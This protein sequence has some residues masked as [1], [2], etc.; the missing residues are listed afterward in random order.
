MRLRILSGNGVN[1]DFSPLERL[2]RRYLPDHFGIKFEDDAARLTEISE[3]LSSI[4][5][6][7]VAGK[8]GFWHSLWGHLGDGNW[9]LDGWIA[10][11]PND[12]GLAVVKTGLAVVFKVSDDIERRLYIKI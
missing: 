10:L 12:Y 11:I 1:E 2:L 4:E 6:G 9:A 3:R 5:D 8:S 7:F